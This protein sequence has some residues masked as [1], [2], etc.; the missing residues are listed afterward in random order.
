MFNKEK[1]TENFKEA[2]TIIGRSIKVKGN[3][4]GQGNV[5]IEGRLEGSLKTNANLLIGDNANITANIEAK[6]A[7]INGSVEGNIKIKKYLSIG[8]NAKIIGDIQCEEIS[9]ARGAGLKGQIA[10]IN[11]NEE[12]KEKEAAKKE[13]K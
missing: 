9:I 2:E 8:K 12:N 5:I 7:I 3:F 4:N 6:E 11:S 1:K 10:I 13:L